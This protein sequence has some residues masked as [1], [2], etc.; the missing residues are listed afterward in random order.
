VRIPS[1]KQIQ[2]YNKKI[3]EN[4]KTPQD[5][6]KNLI[7]KELQKQNQREQ[8]SLI[9]D[10]VSLIMME[11]SLMLIMKDPSEIDM[12][13]KFE[14][15]FPDKNFE[16]EENNRKRLSGPSQ[17]DSRVEIRLLDPNIDW[18]QKILTN[19]TSV[20]LV[21]RKENLQI[22]SD[23]LYEIGAPNTLGK[24]FGL[25]PGQPFANQ[26]IGG[27]G[28]CFL[29]NSKEIMSACHVFNDDITDYAIVFGFEL[30]NKVGAFKTFI[31]RS[32]VYFPSRQIHR[33][34]EIDVIILELDRES[35][36]TP[37]KLSTSM[38]GPGK[39]IYMLGHPCGIPL[40]VSLN[41]S[42]LAYEGRNAFYTSLDAFQGNSGSP[43]FNFETHEVIGMLVSGEVDF[44]WNGSCNSSRICGVPYCKGEKAMRIEACSPVGDILAK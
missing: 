2:E 13:L 24:Q 36:R 20:A 8:P 38:P 35:E 11:Q 12:T 25:C 21:V 43:I 31:P 10:T 44:S 26:Y 5:V 6:R 40:K 29:I 14:K 4:D 27:L 32:N 19:G 23:S 17:F 15:I 1:T 37:L 22:V 39:E 16:S 9:P 3:F 42:V 33:D 41:A 28:T 18:Q 7:Q 34:E 30:L